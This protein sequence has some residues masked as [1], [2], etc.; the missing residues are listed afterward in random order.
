M[1]ANTVLNRPTPNDGFTA[2]VARAI[3]KTGQATHR[4]NPDAPGATRHRTACETLADYVLGLPL[5]DSRFRQLL[6]VSADSDRF[7]LTGSGAKM[8]QLLGLDV[9]APSDTGAVFTEF[10]IECG[11]RPANVKAAVDAKAAGVRAE[12]AASRIQDHM[13][14][15]E[16][17]AELEKRD[18]KASEQ[19]QELSDLRGRLKAMPEREVETLSRKLAALEGELDQAN[20]RAVAAE[21]KGR[22][23]AR[24]AA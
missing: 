5:W 18:R 21:R 8:I 13:R 3:R 12:L 17:E 20:R 2:S 19:S 15:S 7:T 6:K 16:L 22:K 14:I 24:A 1:D 23:R 4:S 9:P 11:T 10:V